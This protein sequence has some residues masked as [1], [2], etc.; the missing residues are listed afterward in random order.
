MNTKFEKDFLQDVINR[1]QH[2]YGGDMEV[3]AAVCWS[4][5][6]ELTGVIG[7]VS[8]RRIVPVVY[9]EDI[10]ARASAEKAAYIITR[11]IH[12]M[13]THKAIKPVR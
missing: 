7:R 3:S 9:L 5:G 10:P 8:D 6:L 11:K 2:I 13:L 1:I 12:S 4:N